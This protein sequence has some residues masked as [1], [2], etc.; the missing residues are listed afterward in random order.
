MNI[1]N[2]PLSADKP[3]ILNFQPACILGLPF[4]TEISDTWA[5][6]GSGVGCGPNSIKTS[7]GEYFERKHFY[8]DV[9]TDLENPLT[10][11]LSMKEI[12]NF[13]K[14]FSQ[15]AKVPQHPTQL[16]QHTYKLTK[17]MRTSN[18][19]ECHIPTACISLNHYGLGADNSI[20]PS[21]DTCGCSFHW[22]AKETMFGSIKEC[23][24]RQ[25]LSRFWLTGQAIERL[26]KQHIMRLM[27]QSSFTHLAEALS[28]AGEL[29]AFD[30]S[31]RSFPGRCIILFYGQKDESRHVKYCTGM[32]Y[33][34]TRKKAIQKALEELWQ[35]YRFMN[36]FS[37]C[38]STAN[39]LKDPYLKHFMNC[40]HYACFQEITQ[41][42]AAPPIKNKTSHAFTLK[43]LLDTLK[44]KS[45]DGYFYLKPSR[46][47][48]KLCA[49]SKFISP[50][51]FMHMDNSKHINMHNDYSKH[52]HDFILPDRQ[53]IMVPFP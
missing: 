11:S 5:V 2:T 9:V 44:Y 26:D 10:H 16:Q 21:K 7:L 18:F 41:T 34:S 6:I 52:F 14:A 30:I 53:K 46:I 27:D 43:G 50:Q 35:T 38:N 20:Y 42:K 4:T 28:H 23:L 47:E 24:E 17:V 29:V 40:N 1:T 8:T 45:I 3:N 25:F 51:L 13:T 32:A 15:T 12:K 48:G 39:T 33:S 22:N 31:D 19:T 49:F 37:S 36:L